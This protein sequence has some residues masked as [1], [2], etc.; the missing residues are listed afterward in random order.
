MVTSMTGFGRGEVSVDGVTAT[1]DVRSLNSRYLDL[2]LSIPRSL[3]TQE[4]AIRDLI[5]QKTARGRVSVHISLTRDGNEELGMTLDIAAAKSAYGMLD[6]MRKELGLKDPIELSHVLQFNEVM[7]PA[8]RADTDAQAWEASRKAL[9]L[10]LDAM[11][12]MRAQEGRQILVDIEQRVNGMEATVEKIESLIKAQV[13]H[14]RARLQ[15][16][17]AVL[18]EGREID[19][20]RLSVEVALLADKLDITEECVR[21]RSHV[22][23]FRDMVKSDE[24]AG[25]K[26][27]FLTQE[28]NREINTMGSK[29]EDPEIA[30]AVVSMKEELEKIREQV[31]NIE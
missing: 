3:N 8:E 1:A 28:L 18:L 31:Q 4:Q 14:R 17:L 11:N 22:M 9:E 25:R 2:S 12:A 29:A 7:K 23:F 10:A 26:M 15:E 27:N 30:R 6:A 20:Q 13:T 19:D 5:R 24:P 21:F 16:R